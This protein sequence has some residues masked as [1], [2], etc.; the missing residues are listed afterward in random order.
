MQDFITELYVNYNCDL[1][2][3]NIFENLTKMLSKNAFQVTSLYSTPIV[4]DTRFHYQIICQFVIRA[5]GYIFCNIM[6]KLSGFFKSMKAFEV[7]VGNI[8]RQT[9]GCGQH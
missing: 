1:Y 7:S 5:S 8:S 6:N 3:H 4:Q 9:D 2:T